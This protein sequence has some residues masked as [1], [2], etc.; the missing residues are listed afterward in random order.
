[1]RGRKRHLAVDTNGFLLLPYVTG[2]EAW[3]Y[4]A[5]IRLTL[6]RLC[7]PPGRKAYAAL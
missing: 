2:A 1:M 6:R 3:M 7:P 4:L 5:L